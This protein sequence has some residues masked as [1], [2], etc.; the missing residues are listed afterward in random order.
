MKT[1]KITLLT[2]L[3]L[4]SLGAFSQTFNA[5]DITPVVGDGYSL[6]YHSQF[7]LMPGGTN[8]SWNF[9][10]MTSS[11]A[12]GTATTNYQSP[13]ST[14]NASSF[15]TSTVAGVMNQNGQTATT[16]H[17]NTSS[18]SEVLGQVASGVEI[19]FQNPITYLEF[20]VQYNSSNTDTY[21][22][23]FTTQGINFYRRGSLVTT[24]D[25]AGTLILPYG[26][27]TNVLRVKTVRKEQDSANYMGTELI[28][29]YDITTYSYFIAGQH[30]PLVMQTKMLVDGMSQSE[31]TS[32]ADA[33]SIGI[34]L[35]ES[36]V[37]SLVYP[38]PL[39]KGQD[40]TI[41]LTGN[42]S[43]ASIGIYDTKGSCV[44][45]LTTSAFESGEGI[46]KIPTSDL[47]AGVYYIRMMDGNKNAIKIEKLVIL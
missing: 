46:Y 26:T 17:K 8:A 13:S 3:F 21:S 34:E 9:A 25:G 47:D 39:V 23:N 11:G 15:P 6:Y 4:F 40:V 19:V 44:K 18:I 2:A 36:E 7:T 1:K 31:M 38:N 22:S 32:I 37:K 29:K 12:D 27:Y 45:S 10:S 35:A 28:T 41:D 16:Y 14:P 33:S 42:V 43:T 5:Y 20:P 30:F 24:T